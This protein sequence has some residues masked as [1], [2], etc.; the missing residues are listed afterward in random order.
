MRV[1]TLEAQTVRLRPYRHSGCVHEALIEMLQGLVCILLGFK[2]HKAELPELAVFG[3]FQRAVCQS[4]KGS[5][6][7]PEPVLL[8]LHREQ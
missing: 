8:H 6:H 3:K 2:T 1:F 4:A 7:R 5:K